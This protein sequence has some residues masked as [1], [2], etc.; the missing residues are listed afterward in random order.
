MVVS[1]RARCI[2]IHIQKTGGASIEALL[3]QHDPNMGS[4]LHEGRRHMFARDVRTIAGPE[5]W[6]RYF[7][8]AFVR[9]PWDRLVS[10]Y[11]M[12]MQAHAPNAFSQYVRQHA[13]TFEAFVMDM[14]AGMGKRTTYNQLDYVTDEAGAMLVDFIGRYESLD[15][16]FAQVSERLGLP[17]ELPHLNQS[18]HRHY[19]DYFTDRMRAIVAK[20]FE[21][22]IDYF[23]Y[24]F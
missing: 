18:Q 8:F 11:H 15:R 10:W 16:D 17:L 12:C 19:R 14:T 1:D 21:R 2:F 4:G 20:R 3:R 23:G 22:D 13:P 6:H 7:K 9:N 5:R 24:A